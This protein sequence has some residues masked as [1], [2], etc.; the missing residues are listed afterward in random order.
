MG[1]KFITIGRQFGSGGHKIAQMVANRLNMPYYD[2]ELILMAAQKGGFKLDELQKYD[3]KKN[4]S[5]LYR[6]N[7]SGNA[8][9]I[10]GE[11]MEETLYHLQ[12]MVIQELASQESAVIVG[13]CADRVLKQAGYEVMSIFISAPLEKRIERVMFT[14]AIDEKKAGALI[15]KID[16]RRKKYYESHTGKIWGDPGSYDYYYNTDKFEDFNGVADDIIEKYQR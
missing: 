5:F 2:N 1:K 9:V 7:Y 12:S 8:N 6:A 4:S 10:K 11:S 3:E 16:Q 15:K 13:R 14:E